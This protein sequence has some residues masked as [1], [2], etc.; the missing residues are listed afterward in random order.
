MTKEKNSLVS[1]DQYSSLMLTY[2]RIIHYLVCCQQFTDKL[3]V[4]YQYISTDNI[5]GNFRTLNSAAV[6][7]LPQLPTSRSCCD[8]SD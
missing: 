6:S 2:V 3:P 7:A 5:T 8:I 1:I 4:I